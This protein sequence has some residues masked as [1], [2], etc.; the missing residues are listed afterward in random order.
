MS[1]EIIY[2][3]DDSIFYLYSTESAE[4]FANNSLIH[5]LFYLSVTAFLRP[6]HSTSGVQPD[7]A[8]PPTRAKVAM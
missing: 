8:S 5:R 2:Y 6:C 7:D 4:H 1:P 3:R